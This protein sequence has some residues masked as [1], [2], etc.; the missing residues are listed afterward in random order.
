[1]HDGRKVVPAPAAKYIH[2]SLF[3]RYNVHSLSST[4]SFSENDD[5]LIY[6][7][8]IRRTRKGADA[9]SCLKQGPRAMTS[10][11][12]DLAKATGDNNNVKG[13]KKLDAQ[14]LMAA[15]FVPNEWRLIFLRP[16]ASVWPTQ[17]PFDSLPGV[18]HLY[19]SSVREAPRCVCQDGKVK[20]NVRVYPWTN[21]PGMIWNP[22]FALSPAGALRTKVGFRRDFPDVERDIKSLQEYTKV[23]C[24]LLSEE[25]EEN[26]MLFERY[27]QYNL[28]IKVRREHLK[29]KGAGTPPLSRA[30]LEIAGIYDARPPLQPGDHVLL[31]PMKGT[32]GLQFPQ[33]TTE[34]QATVVGTIRGSKKKP[35]DRVIITWLPET[36]DSLVHGR[37]FAARFIPSST[38]FNRCLTA[39]KWLNETLDPKTSKELLFPSKHPHVQ[40][41]S[42][43]KTVLDPS[44]D[45][46]LQQL[47]AQQYQ[48]VKMVVTRSADPTTER[49]RPPMVLTGPAGTG[50]TKTL[51]TALLKTLALD[52]LDNTT[53][54]R[55]R[56]LVCTPSHTA[57]DVV[58]RRLSKHLEREQIFRLY[59][60]SRPVEMVP[61]EMLGFTRQGAMGEFI[62]PSA[63]DFQKFQVVVCTCSDANLL[64]LSGMTNASMRNRRECLQTYTQ[65]SLTSS[66]LTLNGSIEGAQ[67]PMFT[68]LFVDEAAQASEPEILIPL[69]VVVDDVSVIRKAEIVLSGD[70]RQLNPDIYSR[71]ACPSLQKSFLERLLRLPDF[72]GRNHLLG[73]PTKDTWRTLDE[74]IE[75]SF[76]GEGDK[77]GQIDKRLSVFLTMSYRGHPSFLH[78]PSKLFYLDKLRS[79][80]P[81]DLEDAKW[82]RALRRIESHSKPAYPCNEKQYSWPIHFLG[83]KGQDV[84]LAVESFWG[85]NSWC[86]CE[87][88]EAVAGIVVSLCSNGVARKS[89]GVM[90]A[91]RAQVL[92]IRRL[93][94][95][96]NLDSVNVGMVEDYQSVEREVIIV[97]LTRSNESFVSSDIDR[98]SGLFQQPK[99]VNVALTRAEN[100][101]I[102]VGNPTIMEKDPLWTAWLGYC[103]HHGFWYGEAA[104]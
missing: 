41:G 91:F 2:V 87:E 97:S 53:K 6:G 3:G 19:H 5:S 80:Y 35:K 48:F 66:G 46:E 72:G 33:E 88:A 64:F 30:I 59:D 26:L 24:D 92:H 62:L 85:S 12:E 99:R 63:S 7:V 43:A 22:Q 34:I 76:Q 45:P 47:N 36:E 18:Q 86:N 29:G 51:L 83:V 15:S 103:R 67:V 89:I 56:M 40:V 28:E 11:G 84:S 65:D 55:K 50:K 96:K 8:H 58:T 39:M 32:I 42:A 52:S 81:D 74:L 17:Q 79:V 77:T 71:F 49:I 95:A 82:C 70:P 38:F 78:I 37:L 20:H 69:S 54:L 68:H 14:S 100:L 98:N 57:C 44:Q 1:M 21:L 16:V 101:L 27:T 93:L 94:R 31:R 4:Q 13:K 9:D 102:V 90:A 73:P 25:Y 60:S 104:K 61:V 75:Y 10:T 23:F